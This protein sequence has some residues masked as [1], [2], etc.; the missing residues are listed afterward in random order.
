MGDRPN[1]TDMISKWAVLLRLAESRSSPPAA[2]C[3][4]SEL[5][6]FTAGGELLSRPARMCRVRRRF[7]GA[8]GR[9]RGRMGCAFA[10][11]RTAGPARWAFGPSGERAARTRKN[12]ALPNESDARAERNERSEF[13]GLPRGRRPARAVLRTAGFNSKR[14]EAA[15]LFGVDTASK[16]PYGRVYSERQ[17]N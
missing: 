5:V 17:R 7:S 15:R 4:S 16:T 11:R 13:A 3:N 14:V 2:Y 1:P 10:V 9:A 6:A 12:W 8:W